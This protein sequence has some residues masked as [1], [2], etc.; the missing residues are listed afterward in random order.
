MNERKLP[1]RRPSLRRPAAIRRD[2]KGAATV[3]LALCLPVLLT[4]GLG[5][6]E[7]SN[8]VFIQ[9][10]LQS[11]AY[12]SARLA[13]RPTT[14]SATAATNAQVQTYCQTLLKQLG[15]NGATVT[16]SPANLANAAPQT[17]ATVSISAPWSQNSVTSFLMNNS[18]TLTASTTLVV[19]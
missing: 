3:E 11:A 18:L 15:V 13:T 16:V 7:T 9:S 4:I 12:E 6:I 8:V 19:E 2:R 5:M 17:L 1:C 10:R 14:S